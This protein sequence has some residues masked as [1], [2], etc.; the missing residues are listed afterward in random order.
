MKKLFLAL[1]IFCLFQAAF[2]Q[3]APL[4]QAEYVKMLYALQKAP[5]TKADIIEALRKRGID[6][7][8]TDGIRSLT[9][10]K[11]ANDEELK[12]ALEEAGRRKQ[13]PEGAKLP[14]AKDASEVLENARKNT[15]EA[16]EEM[17]DFVVKQQVQR[18][19]AFA[20]TG[21]YKN[22]DRLVVAV[23]YRT[24]GEEDYR[25]LSMNGILQNDPKAKSSYEE[26]GG[27]SS[28]GEFVTMLAIIFKPEN[29]TKFTL[30]DSDFIRQRK[31]LVFDFET[32]RE[33]AQEKIA[34]SSG[35]GSPATT[36]S[37]IKGRVWIDRKDG[38]V[39]RIESEATEIPVTFPITS[40]KRIIDYDWVTISDGKYLLPSLS[41]VR[42]VARESGKLIETRNVIRFKEYQKYGSD[43]KILDDDLKPEPEA[44]KP[45]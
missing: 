2:A 29:E 15:L 31:A 36:V 24:T 19:W 6:F 26:A 37:G 40:A 20:G 33:K 21:S 43:V 35:S 12:R 42:L 7:V 22:L 5:E 10:S 41:D 34:Y 25:L 17:P 27:T 14:S 11:G 44:K 16:V 45:N 9:R 38:R 30:S 1:T 3:T 13:D 4:T 8:L 18:S 39:L 28:T 32:I 23:S